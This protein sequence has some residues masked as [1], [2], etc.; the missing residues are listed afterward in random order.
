MGTGKTF[1]TFNHMHDFTAWTQ[2]QPSTKHLMYYLPAVFDLKGFTD[3]PPVGPITHAGITVFMCSAQSARRYITAVKSEIAAESSTDSNSG[4]DIMKKYFIDPEG[5]TEFAKRLMTAEPLSDADMAQ[6]HLCMECKWTNRKE[7]IL[8][9]HTS[10]I[11]L[12]TCKLLCC[13]VAMR[14]ADDANMDMK[15]IT[16]KEA[17][18]IRGNKMYFT[19]MQNDTQYLKKDKAMSY[20]VYREIMADFSQHLTLIEWVDLQGAIGLAHN[21]NEVL[22]DGA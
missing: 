6:L 8:K 14:P 12:C 5:D 2:T 15:C 20:S 1:A 18:M 17:E 11:L 19:R 4:I 13:Y 7:K 16:P 21:M 3:V 9:S 10:K 22:M